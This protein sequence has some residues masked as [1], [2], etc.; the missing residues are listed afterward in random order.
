MWPQQLAGRENWPVQVPGSLPVDE[1]TGH[2]FL[3]IDTKLFHHWGNSTAP[4]SPTL[5]SIQLTS[6][7]QAPCVRLEAGTAAVSGSRCSTVN[8]SSVS[9]QHLSG[10]HS[11]SCTAGGSFKVNRFSRPYWPYSVVP[12]KLS[13]PK[14]LP[15][16][17][18]KVA[19]WVGDITSHLLH[20]SQH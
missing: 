2:L 3:G 8:R 19:G 13:S 4:W 5:A 10:A 20:R 14:Q 9:Q 17:T 12:S 6:C 18:Y 1:C 15:R 16:H 7:C 11:S